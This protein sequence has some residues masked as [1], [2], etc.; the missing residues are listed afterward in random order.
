MATNHTLIGQN[1]KFEFIVAKDIVKGVR[2]KFKS[3]NTYEA[4][5]QI[6]MEKGNKSDFRQGAIYFRK[7][8]KVHMKF[9]YPYNQVVISDGKFIWIYLPNLKLLGKQDLTKKSED[10]F[11][12]KATPVGLDRLF[13]LYHYTFQ[14]G[15]QPRKGS[16]LK[17]KEE[18]FYVLHLRQ[19]VITSGFKEM[20][21]WVDTG[22]LVRKVVAENALGKKITMEFSNIQ[23]DKSFDDSLFT[24]NEKDYK[25]KGIVQNPLVQP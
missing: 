11:F 3:F 18:V 23:T 14:K 13:S 8:D 15:E 2:Q 16:I 21:V 19:K 6:V 9:T 12:S 1:N 25:V 24:F 5:F 17:G 7:P 22:F 4:Q 20:E 10:G